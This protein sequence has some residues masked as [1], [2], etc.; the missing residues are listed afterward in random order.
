MN[1]N[2]NNQNF[3]KRLERL[4]NNQA[5]TS[6]SPSGNND[7]QITLEKLAQVL[8]ETRRVIR[9]NEKKNQQEIS[10]LQAKL[11]S[12]EKQLRCQDLWIR[13]LMETVSD[14]KH[15]T[16]QHDEIITQA[17][18]RRRGFWPFGKGQSC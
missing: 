18:P 16:Q 15:T 13:D 2:E 3:K 12:A 4:T 10:D 9:D 6:P 17:I 1:N 11:E 7:D 14:L 5:A 8:M